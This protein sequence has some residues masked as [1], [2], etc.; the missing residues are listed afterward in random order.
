MAQAGDRTSATD[1]VV[2]AGRVSRAY[3]WVLSNVRF[4]VVPAWVAAAV[5]ATVYLPSLAQAQGGALGSLVPQNAPA[6]KAELRAFHFFKIPLEAHVAVVQRDAHG[7]SIDAQ[8]RVLERALRI[9]ER[10]DP[11]FRDIPGAIPVT[12]TLGLFPS[13]RERSTTAVTF[14][15]FSPD[16]GL[17]TQVAAAHRFAATIHQRGDSLIGVTGAAPARLEETNRITGALPWVELATILLIALVVGLYYRSV[18]APLIALGAAALAYVVSVHVVAWVSRRM[19]VVLPSELEPVV[20]VLLLG[21]VTDYSVFFLSGMRSRLLAGERTKLASRWTTAAYA[22]IVVVAGLTV[23]AGTAALLVARL[24]FLRAFGPGLAITVLISL[25]VAVSF[26]PAVLGMLGRVAYWPGGLRGAASSRP[27]DAVTTEDER[28]RR[29]WRGRAAHAATARP[30]A[31]IIAI[32]C[33]AGLVIAATG[34]R[35]TSL[36]FTLIQGLPGDSE[37]KRA[38]DAASKG[39]APG[40]LD[41]TIVLV[42]GRALDRNHDALA[43][44]QGELARQAGVAG[45]LGPG[46]QPSSQP[47]GLF[48]AQ[49]GGAAR[50]VVILADDPLSGAAMSR[51][52]TLE[53][54]VPSL[55]ARAGLRGVTFGYTGDTALAAETIQE[56]DSDFYRVA[57]LTLAIDLLLLILFLRSLVAPVFLMAASVLALAAAIGVTSYVFQGSLHQADLGYYVPYAAAVLLVS[58]GSD[59]NIFVVGRIWEEARR[60]P[61]RDAISLAAPKASRT[62]AVAGVALACSFAL[63]GIVNLMDFRELAFAMF[64][65]ILIDSFIVRSLLVPALISLFGRSSGWPWAHLHRAEPTAVPPP[66]VPTAERPPHAATA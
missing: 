48:V 20:V 64:A 54:S 39:F 58:L 50:F 17:Q 47:A 57:L 16:E 62:I 49:G 3:A 5:A 19:G 6:I 26:T 33:V 53:A 14:L 36:G 4:L 43:A 35:R 27:G 46:D 55:A 38:A 24:G 37:V 40:I 29:S 11:R 42:Q 7:L 15:F 56:V 31:A 23:A 1:E 18:V 65:G 30:A 2:P 22:P 10:S 21:I 13:S 28:I 60:L 59:Y 44:L 12:N 8:T 25:A 52:R 66:P 45:V 41:P 34:L 9:D 63:L 32:V 51:I 61:L